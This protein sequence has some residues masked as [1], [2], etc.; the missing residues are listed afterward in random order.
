MNLE[1][2]ELV[3]WVVVVGIATSSLVS[4]MS[5]RHTGMLKRLRDEIE[6][7]RER[8]AAEEERLAAIAEQERRREEL[9]LRVHRNSEERE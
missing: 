9:R 3:M 8:Q 1:N 7:E 4:M 5:I 6:T 2:W